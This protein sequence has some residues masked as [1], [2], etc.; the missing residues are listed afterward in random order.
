MLVTCTVSGI[1][2]LLR[3]LYINSYPANQ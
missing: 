3:N 1:S 2:L